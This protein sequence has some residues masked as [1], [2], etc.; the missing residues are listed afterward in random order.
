MAQDDSI[1]KVKR[2]SNYD[3]VKHLIGHPHLPEVIMLTE[4]NGFHLARVNLSTGDVK[5]HRIG[6]LRGNAK[7]HMALH[8]SAN[9]VAISINKDIY[10]YT[11]EPNLEATPKD[12]ITIRHP[13]DPSKYHG[14]SASTVLQLAYHPDGARLFHLTDGGNIADNGNHLGVHS[15]GPLPTLISDSILD[16]ASQKL[17][18]SASGKTV[19]VASPGEFFGYNTDTLSKPAF[20][21][22]CRYGFARSVQPI[23]QSHD[24]AL[25]TDLGWLQF[26]ED[27]HKFTWH[28]GH[29]DTVFGLA[30]SRTG[31]SMIS[32]GWDRTIRRWAKIGDVWTEQAQLKIRWPADKQIND[33]TLAHEEREVIVAQH[34]Y[35]ARWEGNGLPPVPSF[36]F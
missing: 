5:L 24:L 7:T 18:I 9:E 22:D 2:F 10:R 29:K 3:S 19:L 17:A 11:L 25:G 15:L 13:K 4:G 21:F 35:L 14:A 36:N 30:F 31:K 8:P 16:H 28:T 1:G 6:N 23:P 27:N 33:V 32:V 26:N 20:K 34:N 12:A